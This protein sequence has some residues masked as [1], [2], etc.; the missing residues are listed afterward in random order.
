MTR[1]RFL[2]AA[3][4]AAVAL[5]ATWWHFASGLSAEER[6][7]VGEW[8]LRDIP[9]APYGREVLILRSDRQFYLAGV[10]RPDEPIAPPGRWHLRDGT[11]ILDDETSAVRRALRPVLAP[12]GLCRRLADPAPVDWIGDREIAITGAENRKFVWKR[13]GD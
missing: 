10:G 3:L 7:L 2:L 13:V 5:G 1:R 8:E 12:L 11:L 6:R 9:P 4:I